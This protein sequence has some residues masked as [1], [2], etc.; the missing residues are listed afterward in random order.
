[1]EYFLPS[2]KMYLL[3]ELGFRFELV[4]WQSNFIENDFWKN[5]TIVILYTFVE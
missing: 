5:F 2:L 3:L 4:A 1:M